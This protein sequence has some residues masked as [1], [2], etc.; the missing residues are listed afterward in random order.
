MCCW[1]IRILFV[2]FYFYFFFFILFFIGKDS[3]K[4]LKKSGNARKLVAFELTGK[5]MVRGGYDVEID[6]EVELE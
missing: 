5:G 2:F 6:G 3:L 1:Y 4:A